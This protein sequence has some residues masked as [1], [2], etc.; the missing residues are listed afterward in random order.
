MIDIK[1]LEAF[2]AIL[3][4]GSISRA[5]EEIGLTQPALS[6]KLKKMEQELGVPLFQRTPRS[7]IPL[8]AAK[9]MAPRARDIISQLDGVRESLSSS[10]RDLR[11]Q[12]RIGCLTGWFDPLLMKVVAPVA[13][14]APNVRLRLH[15]D[16]TENLL[17]MV[18]HGR[19]DMAIVAQPFERSEDVSMEHLLDEELV[20]VGRSLPEWKSIQEKRLD[21][22]KR[23]WVSMKVPDPL[24]DKWWRQKFEGENFPWEEVTVPCSTDHITAIPKVMR[25]IPNSVGVV[26]RQVV[27]SPHASEGLQ[28]VESIPEDNGL[29]LI[30]RASGLELR[31][32]QLVR[33][34]IIEQAKAY[35][36]GLAAQR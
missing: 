11:G 21:L 13:E 18:S 2:L 35:Q 32:Y 29:F 15:V 30:W 10:I 19:L 25:C 6:L 36:S 27:A 17:H 23:P 20:L 12:V 22:L 34:K 28:L 31:R 3:D 33:E 7:V 24:I 1:D 8:E 4:S 9:L 26:P 16:Q 5:A 14:V